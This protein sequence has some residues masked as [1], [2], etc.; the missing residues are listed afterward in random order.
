MLAIAARGWKFERRLVRP[1]NLAA[2][3]HGETELVTADQNGTI[4]WW[5]ATGAPQTLATDLG[6]IADLRAL[7]DH[8]LATGAGGIAI[9]DASHHLTSHFKPAEQVFMSVAGPATDE[10]TTGQHEAIV[11]YD[12][13]GH[14]RRRIA[15]EP[16]ETNWQP[17]FDV[18]GQFVLVSGQGVMSYIELR[19][20]ARHVLDRGGIAFPAISADG[21]QIAFMNNDRDIQFLDAKGAL[22]KKLHGKNDPTGIAFTPDGKRF[23]TY[24]LRSVIVYET[25]TFKIIHQFSIEPDQLQFAVRDDDVWTGGM[26]GTV[27]RYHA[28]TLVASLPNAGGQIED[29][30]VTAVGVAVVTSDASLTIYDANAAQFVVDPKPCEHP[31]PQS[32]SFATVVG[33]EDARDFLFIG[34]TKIAEVTDVGMGDVA[35]G[36]N[37]MVAVGD[38]QLR[39]FDRDGKLIAHR[40]ARGMLAFATADSLAVVEPK[41]GE[42][43]RW[44]FRNDQWAKLADLKDA[45]AI[46]VA[47]GGWLVA[48]ADGRVELRHDG[49]SVLHTEKLADR[50]EFLTV[51]GNW[52]AAQLAS[53]GTVILDGTTAAILRSF[54][55]A[56]SVG[57][58]STLDPTGEL[59]VRPSRGTM[60]LWERASGDELVWNL[61]LIKGAVNAAVLGDGRI[62]LSGFA[63]G[64]LDIPRDQ[65]PV[66]QLLRDLACRVPLRVV[67]SRL[68]PATPNCP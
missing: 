9:V 25:A 30:A 46:A 23:I 62:E 33:C 41:T 38:T 63:T 37:D 5:P 21:S 34:R 28:G 18:H 57:T 39:V 17:V 47:P 2:M 55:P 6:D 20:G 43:A 48:F 27:R 7:G 50:V 22:G 31:E 16:E 29:I 26:D 1:A 65:R 64:V 12:L 44:N 53:G 49:G 15:L 61:D 56:D 3:A 10:I 51:T 35:R 60:T 45:T 40:D 8:W 52:V 13:T 24:G 14:E 32:N 54:A 4:A 36:P 67:N 68:E 66:D 58:A 59:V 42:L 11:T 19:T